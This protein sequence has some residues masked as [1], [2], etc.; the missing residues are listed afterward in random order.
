MANLIKGFHHVAI[1]TTKFDETVTFYKAIGL[2]PHLE[3]GDAGERGIMLDLGNGSYIEAFEKP[4]VCE[5]EGKLVHVAF[6]SDDPDTCYNNAISAG[7]TKHMEP[8]D[9]T[10]KAYSGDCKVRIAFVYGL[11]G[12]LLEF[13]KTY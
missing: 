2:T 10:I 12:E 3:W 6:A 13:F 11:N 8:Q 9:I 7:A 4:S 5:S 1:N